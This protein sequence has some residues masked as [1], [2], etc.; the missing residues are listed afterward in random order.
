MCDVEKRKAYQAEYYQ[1]NTKHI[2]VQHAEYREKNKKHIAAYREKNKERIATTISVCMKR[3]ML[4]LRTQFYDMYG[5][6]KEGHEHGVCS[7]LGCGTDLVDFGTISHIDGSGAQHREFTNG[8]ALKIIKEALAI[9]NPARFAAEC[10][11]C[12]LAAAKN[13]GVCPH[14]SKTPR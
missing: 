7:C 11:N 12:N 14:K 9:Y 5:L 8:S 4:T 13:D 1:K 3:R 10:Y 6:K 2:A